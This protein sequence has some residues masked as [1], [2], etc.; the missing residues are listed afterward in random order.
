MSN[1]DLA[2]NRYKL[3]WRTY[4]SVSVIEVKL[5]KK[6]SKF[7]EQEKQQEIRIQKD[8]MYV[9]TRLFTILYMSCVVIINYNVHDELSVSDW[10]TAGFW[11][12][13]EVGKE[14]ERTSV[15]IQLKFEETLV[16][17]EGPWPWYS[18]PKQWN[19]SQRQRKLLTHKAI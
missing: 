14:I 1:E 6:F 12:W 10:S 9:F 16:V 8:Y 15:I 19:T 11:S 5:T 7:T 13:L 18:L 17:S 4:L 3:A 2:F